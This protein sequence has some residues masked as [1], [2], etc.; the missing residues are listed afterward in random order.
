MNEKVD[1]YDRLCSINDSWKNDPSNSS[2]R[3]NCK[4]KSR[5]SMGFKVEN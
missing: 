4:N 1:G 5:E 2:M 3:N